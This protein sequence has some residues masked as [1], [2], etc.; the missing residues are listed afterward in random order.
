MSN[1]N[2]TLFC[3]NL[4]VCTVDVLSNVFNDHFVMHMQSQHL[5]GLSC[6]GDVHIRYEF[7]NIEH[8]CRST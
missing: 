6:V 5:N 3:T 4:Q 8:T 7:D 1:L 2:E